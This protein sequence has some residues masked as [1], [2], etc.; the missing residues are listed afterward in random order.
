MLDFFYLLEIYDSMLPGI[1]QWSLISQNYSRCRA[2][3]STGKVIRDHLHRAEAFSMCEF[4]KGRAQGR[5]QNKYLDLDLREQD[6]I[7]WVHR[8]GKS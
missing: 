7:E 5:K 1:S 8:K 3:I 2:H 6:R 4:F